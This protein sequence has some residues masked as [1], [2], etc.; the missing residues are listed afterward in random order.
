MNL[1]YETLAWGRT[2]LVNF[3]AGKT[4]LIS[5]GWSKNT[6]AINVKMNG[7]ALEEKSSLRYW[8]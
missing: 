7:Y 3:N 1:T 4:Q 2:W 6:D 8:A 5:F